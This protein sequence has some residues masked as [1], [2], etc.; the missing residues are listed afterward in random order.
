MVTVVAVHRAASEL[1][2]VMIAL[3]ALRDDP[4]VRAVL[5]MT[6]QAP[7]LLAMALLMTALAMPDVP[8]GGPGA[9]DAARHLIFREQT[10]HYRTNFKE[11]HH[12]RT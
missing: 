3:W 10:A 9:L 4:E 11:T 12:R 7:E 6:C 1:A 5:M 8:A 2:I